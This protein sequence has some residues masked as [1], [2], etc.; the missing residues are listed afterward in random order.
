MH[1]DPIS[2]DIIPNRS[3]AT[4]WLL[5]SILLMTVP[6]NARQTDPQQNQIATPPALQLPAL[7]DLDAKIKQ[8]NTAKETLQDPEQIKQTDNLIALYEQSRE[9]LNRLA[10]FQSALEAFANVRTGVPG[11]LN[12]IKLDIEKYSS[13]VKI[14]EPY[15]EWP[16]TLV[17]QKRA[18]IQ[19]DLDKAKSEVAACE[20]D[21][22][23]RTQRRTEIPQ[24]TTQ[25]QQ[26]IEEIKK[27]LAAKPSESASP[28]SIE[29][30]RILLLTTQNALQ[31]QIESNNEE[32]LSYDARGELLTARRNLAARQVAYNDKLAQQWQLIL[33]NKRKQQADLATQQARQ[34]QKLAAQSHPV[35][36]NLAEQNVTLAE[37]RTGTNGLIAN[38][39]LKNQYRKNI[40]NQHDKLKKEFDSIKERIDAVGLTNV[41]GVMLVNQ[42]TQLPNIRSHQKTIRDRQTET[43]SAYL[44]LLQH[45]ESYKDLL[46]NFENSL[47]TYT[48]EVLNTA[49]ESNLQLQKPDIENE[50]RN[51]LQIKQQLLDDLIKEYENYHSILGDLD[52]TERK[53]VTLTEEFADYIDEN[54]LWIKSAQTINLNTLSQSKSA[55]LWLIEPQKLNTLLQQTARDFKNK[56]QYYILV[57]SLCALL[58]FYRLRLKNRIAR[59]AS[60]VQGKHSDNISHTIK[61]LWWSLLY[62]LPTPLLLYFLGARLKINYQNSDYIFA[63]SAGLRFTALAYFTLMLL[64][65]FLMRG[66]LAAAHFHLPENAR[67][68]FRK[69]LL[70]FTTFLLPLMF[71]IVVLN[72]QSDVNF[73]ETLGKLTLIAALILTSVLFMI[74]LKPSG[75]LIKN[76]L[77]EKKGGWLDRLRFIWYALFFCL[78]LFFAFLAALGYHYAARQLTSC[79]LAS[80]L[81]ALIILFL[82]ALSQR[83]LH[84]TQSRLIYRKH[85]LSRHET[86]TLESAE[87]PPSEKDILLP[88]QI[89]PEEELHQ[90]T[91]QSKRFI[92][93]FAAFILILGFWYIWGDVFPA[94]GVLNKVPL[95]T[96]TEITWANLIW[97]LLIVIITFVAARDILGLLEV[98]V[99]QRLPLDKGGQFAV[100]TITRYIIV[101]VGVF[102]AFG[103]I[104]IGWSKVQ[105]LVAALSVGLGF[106]LQEIFANFI[107]GLLILFEQPIRVGDIVTVDNVSGVVTKISIRA[108]TVRD[109]D[110]K[111]YL[112]PNKDFITGRLLNWTLTDK[113]NR[114]VINVG[115]NY[116]S[117][118]EL[119]LKTLLQVAGDHPLILDDPKPIVTFE[120]FGDNSLNLVLRCFLPNL[121][122]RLPTISQLYQNIDR[123]FRK[124]NIGIAFPQRDLHIRSI[125]LP[126]PFQNQ[127]P[128]P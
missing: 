21:T 111:E 25:A 49:D 30:N 118:V 117:N 2:R 29:A 57:L 34:A 96:S 50:I 73:I 15:A 84:V 128:L 98:A 45:Q 41:F 95:W 42:R 93:Y 65:A 61:V 48:A 54:V 38:I 51:L 58:I 102:L 44:E 18:Q 75:Q 77:Q 23:I 120:G 14:E 79:L 26:K 87:A 90:L 22:K 113:T 66:G 119:A 122:E 8:L 39:T 105:W 83:V 72:Q 91:R 70:R 101:I 5:G 10:K 127:N 62:A 24:E 108:T 36:K 56:P 46:D 88:P 9:Q 17:E 121:D 106:G 97:F 125:D 103:Q 124:H 104:G 115:I 52:V 4:F 28:E 85:L 100:I 114:I 86:I 19:I 126:I 20:N 74:V 31:K 59:T 6:L 33:E 68:F 3:R 60:L 7:S 92:N 99:L 81:L 89:T 71:L 123:E 63:V 112:V 53:L 32:I 110:R 35:I 40:Q 116:G 27:Q 78:P 107:S 80:L 43:A 64:R 12:D 76:L 11:R 16:I 37:L 82:S 55:L 67:I 94:L 47:E 69:N 1:P 109:W 13:D